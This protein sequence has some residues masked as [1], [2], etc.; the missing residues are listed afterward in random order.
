MVRSLAC[1]LLVLSA[2]TAIEDVNGQ[3]PEMSLSVMLR[4]TTVPDA[5]YPESKANAMLIVSIVVP[6]GSKLFL[7]A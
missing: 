6:R 3:G 1:P 7:E 4:R 2:E 5:A